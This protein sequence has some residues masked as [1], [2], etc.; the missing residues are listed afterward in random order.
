MSCPLPG[1]PVMGSCKQSVGLFLL[2]ALG[3]GGELRGDERAWKGGGGGCGLSPSL[4]AVSEPIPQDAVTENIHGLSRAPG[5]LL[6]SSWS[7]YPELGQLPEHLPGCWEE[8]EQHQ[9]LGNPAG[10][11]KTWG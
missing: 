1:S 2:T 5:I 10:I 11:A 4:R 7:T 8:T 3:H 6:E 9:G